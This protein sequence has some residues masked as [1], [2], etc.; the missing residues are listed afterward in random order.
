MK[1]ERYIIKASVSPGEYPSVFLNHEVRQVVNEHTYNA[2]HFCS[3]LPSWK[4]SGEDAMVYLAAKVVLLFKYANCLATT[5][6][7]NNAK[8][9]MVFECEYFGRK[10]HY[11][12]ETNFRIIAAD[13]IDE[14]LNEYKKIIKN[15]EIKCGAIELG[16][17]DTGFIDRV[18]HCSFKFGL[19][20]KD[21]KLINNEPIKPE[22]EY[23]CI[24]NTIVDDGYE[25]DNIILVDDDMNVYNE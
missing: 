18:I 12:K 2:L 5:R 11:P 14:A 22:Y 9:F 13:D 25:E 1:E 21:I 7:D 3:Y 8:V 16:G 24:L 10:G 6:T 23:H 19:N 20:K 4:Q 15:D 17:M